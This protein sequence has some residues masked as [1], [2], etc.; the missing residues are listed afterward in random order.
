[1]K[2]HRALPWFSATLA[3]CACSASS[4]PQSAGSTQP[5]R[6]LT[7]VARWTPPSQPAVRAKSWL[8]PE[9]RRA[10]APLLFV[11]DA[12]TAEV[13][14]YKLTTLK[15]MGTI[16]GFS[17]PQ[18]ECSDTR[19]DVWIADTIAQKIYEVSHH[20]RLENE[21]ADKSGY[22]VACAWDK[23]SGDLAV[24]NIFNAGS[25]AGEVLVFKKG[26][27]TG[28]PYQNSQQYYYNFGGYDKRG[29]LFFDG[30]DANGNFMLS[31]LPRGSESAHTVILTGGTIYFP[32]MVQWDP[33]NNDLIVG[34]Q[35]CGNSY[36]SCLYSVTVAQSSGTIGTQ[37][38]LQNSAGGQL[39]DLVQG[40]EL[41]GTIAGSDFD[42]CGSTPSATYVWPY[43]A[44][45]APSVYT[46]SA[47]S[48]PVGAAISL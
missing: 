27:N 38:P 12:G 3:L 30:R 14:I 41:N 43:P 42:F 13:Y 29:N 20:G 9:L 39:C 24:M 45:G 17:E 46:K 40:A 16:T 33:S 26:S 32:G 35:S 34:D 44:G 19:G 37:T 7:S 18:G 23:K 10:A 15:L 5:L 47:S 36:T 6:T 4:V 31:E 48:I 28:T 25:V 1:V 22:P 8:S 2:R 21:L 11:S